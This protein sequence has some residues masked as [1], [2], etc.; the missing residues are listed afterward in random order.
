MPKKIN[1]KNTT[2]RIRSDVSRIAA[3]KEINDALDTHTEV[4]KIDL[5][6]ASFPISRDF[7][8]VLSKRFASD[9]YILRVSDKKIMLSAQSLGIQAEVAGIRAEFERKYAS[10]NLTTHN[11]SM[12][13]Y[14]WY[15]I[16]RAVMYVW[17]VL[18]TRKKK[19]KKL[20]HFKKHNGQIILIIAG[21]FVS[22]TLLLF[23]F[24]FAVSK[25]IV[26]VSPQITVESV[27]ANI[28]YKIMTGSLLE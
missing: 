15:E 6:D 23:I 11:M 18:F 24:H 7:L 4:V 8:L 13:E 20:P 26:T 5:L 25:T 28:T 12:L 21:L 1:K 14:L 2:L 3:I 17:F 27:P 22:V 9:R 19:T 16:R 10:D